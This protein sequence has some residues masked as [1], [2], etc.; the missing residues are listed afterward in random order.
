[1]PTCCVHRIGFNRQATEQSTR[2]NT[3][4]KKR[5]DGHGRIEHALESLR[6]ACGVTRGDFCDAIQTI[7]RFFSPFAREPIH[8][9]VLREHGQAFSRSPRTAPRQRAVELHEMA[10]RFHRLPLGERHD[11]IG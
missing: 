8:R 10:N 6:A 1:M 4:R 2:K 11:L 9:L 7:E 5:A 3:V